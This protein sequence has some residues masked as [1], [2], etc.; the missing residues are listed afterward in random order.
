[1][2]RDSFP[3]H[4][5]PFLWRTWNKTYQL[6]SYDGIEE[7]IA[8]RKEA[9]RV[10]QENAAEFPDLALNMRQARKK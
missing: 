4:F 5:L 9:E 10:L 7:A 8:A 6:G 2:A 3:G 1:M